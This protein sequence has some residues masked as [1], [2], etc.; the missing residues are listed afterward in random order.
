MKLNSSAVKKQNKV[1][2]YRYLL[3]NPEKT[4][5]EIA[6]VLQL[7]LPT[8]GQITQELIDTQLISV[9]GMRESSGGRR[10][11]TLVPNVS[12][13]LS[14]GIDITRN[15]IGFVMINLAGDSLAWQRLRI[16][17]VNSDDYKEQVYLLTMEF[18]KKNQIA[19]DTLLGI[20]VS[21]PGI[22]VQDMAWHVKSHALQLD[23]VFELKGFLKSGIPMQYFNDATAACMAEMYTR[24]SPSSFFFLSLSDT[25]GGASVISNQ[26]VTGENNRNGEIGHMCLVP[27]G[28]ECYCGGKG[29]FDAYCSATRLSEKSRKGTLAGFFEE[30]EQGDP[31]CRK[32]FD[33]YLGYLSLMIYNLHIMSDMPV[34]LGGYVGAHL[35][36]YLPELWEKVKKLEIFEQKKSYIKICDYK[37]EAAAVGAARYYTEQYIDNI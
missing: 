35:A 1:S 30:L 34:V 8:V 36:P 5:P 9:S 18:L 24:K 20:G 10:A 28:R 4:K 3:Q 25:V 16:P 6:S 32:V 7:S 31:G 22:V 14:L 37:L 2:I 33:E 26:I 17:F 23:E 19:F 15:H 21:V 29:H 12:R 27:G 11:V 13:N